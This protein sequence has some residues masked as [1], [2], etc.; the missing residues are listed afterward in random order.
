M[1][2]SDQY[3]CIFIHIPKC[4]GTSIEK[5]LDLFR[6]WK[7]PHFDVLFGL[8]KS[9]DYK[10][11]LQHLTVRQMLLHKFIEKQ[12]FDDYFKFSFIRNPWDRALSVFLY[13]G[14][15]LNK[16][17]KLKERFKTKFFDAPPSKFTHAKFERFLLDVKLQVNDLD[18]DSIWCHVS[19][20]NWYLFDENGKKQVD[21]IGR[22][23]NLNAD[24]EYICSTIKM[25][26]TSLVHNNK[27]VRTKPY[28]Y[29]YKDSTRKLV[30]EIYQED[31]D[32]F[33]YQFSTVR[34]KK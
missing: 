23:E 33:N 25:P 22:F 30:E 32:L 13:K 8:L 6:D 28:Q 10:F 34:V 16:R 26:Y 19:P 15:K 14:K 1:P 17:E 31:I 20:Q 18:R 5:K 4:A 29:F 21:F 12:K 2:V 11:E 24:F 7:T 27:S 9:E 3:K